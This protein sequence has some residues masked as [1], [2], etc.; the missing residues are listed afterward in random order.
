MPELFYPELT[1]MVAIFTMIL[2]APLIDAAS[3]CLRL[4]GMPLYDSLVNSFATA[5][6]G[7]FSVRNLSI[8][9]YQSP[10]VEVIITL[11]MLLFSVN[12]GDWFIFLEKTMLV[13]EGINKSESVFVNF[14]FQ[15]NSYIVS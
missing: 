11:F 15:S 1:R 14:R 2:A 5:G 10:T 12:F 8:A 6:T 9:A 7:G 4:A 3:L 13:E